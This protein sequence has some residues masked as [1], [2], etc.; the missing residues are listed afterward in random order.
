M[1]KFD[2]LEEKISR[3]IDSYS[4]LREEKTVLEER[5]AEKDLEI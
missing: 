3:L 4:G 2:I 1:E 5:L